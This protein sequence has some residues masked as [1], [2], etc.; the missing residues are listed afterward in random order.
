[1]VGIEEIGRRYAGKIC[2]TGGCDNQKTLPFGTREEIREEARLLLKHWATPQGGFIGPGCSMIEARG[3]TA[4][5]QY[6]L[7]LQSVLAML[8]AFREFD[9]YRQDRGPL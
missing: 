8:E 9:P 7:P 4:L 3:G 5:E 1:M 2:F 6:G